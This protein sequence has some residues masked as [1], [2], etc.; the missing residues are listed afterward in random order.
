M[1]FSL[2]PLPRVFVPNPYST[3]TQQINSS[4]GALLVQFPLH[5]AITLSSIKTASSAR[6]RAE[7]KKRG[8]MEDSLFRKKCPILLPSSPMSYNSFV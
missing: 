5:R 3:L 4:Y 8:R 6:D 7:D 1:F 2:S